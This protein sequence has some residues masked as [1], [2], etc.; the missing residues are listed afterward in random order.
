MNLNS[1]KNGTRNYCWFKPHHN[2]SVASHTPSGYRNLGSLSRFIPNEVS[3]HHLDR[4]S[5]VLNS[6]NTLAQDWAALRK[7]WK[8]FKIANSHGDRDRMSHYAHIITRLRDDMGIGS[9][10]PFDPDLVEPSPRET[11]TCLYKP[12]INQVTGVHERTCDYETLNAARVIVNERSKVVP[13][14]PEGLYKNAVQPGS[15]SN[16]NEYDEAESNLGA[17]GSAPICPAIAPSP[18]TRSRRRRKSKGNGNFPVHP[19]IDDYPPTCS[20]SR[21]QNRN[22]FAVHVDRTE[23]SCTYIQGQGMTR[24]EFWA[25]QSDLN[26]RNRIVFYKSNT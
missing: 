19:A 12:Q 2:K 4:K 10:R 9:R 21:G 17:S 14:P 13:Y 26:I 3:M 7:A 18:S 23:R 11:K 22:M 15:R 6:G 20:S 25:N 8:G 5:F 16:I 24:E 1:R